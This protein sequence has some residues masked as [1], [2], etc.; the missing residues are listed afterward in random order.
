MLVKY[1]VGIEDIVQFCRDH[2]DALVVDNLID[3]CCDSVPE[4][5]S[6]EEFAAL[7]ES[8]DEQ[9]E[10]YDLDAYVQL[11]A[12]ELEK[13]N[14][15]S[16][17]FSAVNI[18]RFLD[19]NYLGTESGTLYLFREKKS[20]NLTV[21][22]THFNDRLAEIVL[23]GEKNVCCY[24]EPY[25]DENGNDYSFPV[26]IPTLLDLMGGK[27]SLNERKNILLNKFLRKDTFFYTSES[28]MVDYQKR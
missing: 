12:E 24:T 8:R 6:D 21:K 15:N 14:L 3:D 28:T 26:N 17:K 13:Y 22:I 18:A 25:Q 2:K 11:R 20:G 23:A 9:L 16:V 10:E 1:N 4:D 27:L 7:I 19:F 5:I